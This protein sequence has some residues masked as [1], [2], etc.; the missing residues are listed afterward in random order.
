MMVL[1]FLLFNSITTFYKAAKFSEFVKSTENGL[2]PSKGLT[3]IKEGFGGRG[4]TY[5]F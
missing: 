1:G 5:D 3:G 4:I 2:F